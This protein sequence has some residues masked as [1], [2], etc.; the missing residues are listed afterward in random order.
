MSSKSRIVLLFFL[1]FGVKLN[2]QK[3]VINQNLYWIRYFN[4]LSLSEKFTV[5]TEFENR[6]FFEGNQQHH[7]I[8]HSRIHAKVY[9]NTEVAFGLS[10]SRQSPQDPNSTVSLVVPEIRPNQEITYSNAISK[11]FNIQQRFRIDERFIRKNDGKVLMDAYKFNLR[12]RYRLQLAYKFKTELPLTLKIA[13]EI[14]INAGKQIIYNQFD[15][16]RIY[17]GLEKGLNKNF[18]LELGYKYWYQ[19]RTSGNQFFERNII[20]LTANHKMAV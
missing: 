6:S 15:Q 7:L 11:R 8:V 19:Q 18:S 12:F 10:Y 17:T 9:Q 5:H 16:N 13:N 3:A 20:R 14:M 2:A 4:Q 1:L